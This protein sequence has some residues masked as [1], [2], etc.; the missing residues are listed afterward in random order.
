M[1]TAYVPQQ[2][3]GGPGPMT[4]NG[5]QHQGGPPPPPQHSAPGPGMPP[6][7]HGGTPNGVPMGPQRAPSH[8]GQ[9]NPQNIQRVSL[10]EV[11]KKSQMPVYWTISIM[12]LNGYQNFLSSCLEITISQLQLTSVNIGC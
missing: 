11:I 3:H 7:Q 12:M 1:S 6:P 4:H 9:Q 5:P 2:P 8:P 10:K